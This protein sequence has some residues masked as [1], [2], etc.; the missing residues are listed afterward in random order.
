MARLWAGFAKPS[1]VLSLLQEIEQT[2]HLSIL[3]RDPQDAH[4]IVV[5]G[6]L[7]KDM[8]RYPFL[9]LVHQI[10]LHGIKKTQADRYLQILRRGGALVCIDKWNVATIKAVRILDAQEIYVIGTRVGDQCA[11]ANE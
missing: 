10:R 3:I 4:H 2:Q 6:P 8:G 11:W 5:T 1:G 7:S 9:D